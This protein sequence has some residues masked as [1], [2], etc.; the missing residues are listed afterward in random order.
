MKEVMMMMMMVKMMM[1]YDWMGSEPDVR[2]AGD[3]G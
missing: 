2:G 3:D 1:D